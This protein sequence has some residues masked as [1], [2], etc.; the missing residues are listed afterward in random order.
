MLKRLVATAAATALVAVSA[1]SH[2]DEPSNRAT[3]GVSREN[4]TDIELGGT[5][6]T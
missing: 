3:A 5:G 6:M 4:P 2:A 1:L